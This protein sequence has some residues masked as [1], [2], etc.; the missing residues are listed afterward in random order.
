MMMDNPLIG[1]WHLVS[2]HVET[3]SGEKAFPLGEDAKGYISYSRDGFV[4]VH[5]MSASRERY[6][7]DGLFCGSPEEDVAA[8]NS[9]LS[10]SGPYDFQEGQVTHRVTISSHPNW[11]GTEQVRKVHID[12][13]QLELSVGGSQLQ[14][15]DGTTYVIWKK[16]P[17]G[18]A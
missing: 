5:I 1:T 11:V 3:T 13:D 9:Q 7:N 17:A 18:D 4:F 2:W 12:G 16:A 15:F 8:I 14:G 6:E 10:Y